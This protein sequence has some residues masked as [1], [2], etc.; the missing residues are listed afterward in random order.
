MRRNLEDHNRAV[1]PE[2]PVGP[3]ILFSSY[4]IVYRIEHGL[5]AFSEEYGES[6]EW[7]V[8]FE[9]LNG[10]EIGFCITVASDN[11]PPHRAWLQIRTPPH[12]AWKAYSLLMLIR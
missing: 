9:G 10:R 11:F 12:L 6:D 3:P 1:A 7:F 2:P 5:S 8:E 4:R